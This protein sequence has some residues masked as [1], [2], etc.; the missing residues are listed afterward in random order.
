MDNFENQ[1]SPQ[2]DSNELQ[3]QIHSLRQAL[4]AALVLVLVLSGTA[5]LALWRS[6]KTKRAELA[7]ITQRVKD[8]DKAID[9]LSKNLLDYSRTHPDLVPTLTKY[10]IGA[11]KPT[12]PATQA[13]KT[14]PPAG[15]AP[16]SAP[17]AKRP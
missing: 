17:P 4:I 11:S 12:A 6:W 16:T 10:G 3:T 15:K 14:A 1:V 9:V 5:N 13:T 2:P 8:F 7:E